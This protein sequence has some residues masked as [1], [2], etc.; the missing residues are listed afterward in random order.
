M[1][2]VVLGACANNEVEKT[3]E[4]SSKAKPKI[5]R[6]RERLNVAA[7]AVSGTVGRSL[8]LIE[9]LMFVVIQVCKAT[10]SLQLLI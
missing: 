8:V 9:A 10:P 7:P 6:H 3:V 1:N 4:L 2:V 5:R